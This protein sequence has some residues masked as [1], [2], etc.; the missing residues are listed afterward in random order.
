LLKNKSGLSKEQLDQVELECLR[1]KVERM[2]KEIEF[3][4]DRANDMTARVNDALKILDDY[5]KANERYSYIPDDERLLVKSL[6]S[7]LNAET[8]HESQ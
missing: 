1:R 8:N 5:V 4:V 6:R 7:C 2:H 3:A